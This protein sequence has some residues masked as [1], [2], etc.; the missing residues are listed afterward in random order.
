MSLILFLFYWLVMPVLVAFGAVWLWKKPRTRIGKAIVAAGVAASAGWL[1][2]LA[3][4]EKML[5]DMRVNRLCAKDGG[6]RVY[7]SVPLTPDL[8]DEAGRISIPDQARAKPS[9]PYFYM[10]RR[11]V[12]V[13][14]RAKVT[15]RQVQVVRKVDGKILGEK[16][17]YS[18][19]GGELPGPWH[20]S[21][22]TCP[23]PDVSRRFESEIFVGG[24]NDE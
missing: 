6:I 15:R 22:F 13:D 10:A 21:G 8:L 9:D 23:S 3:A 18:R 4:G 2:W 17:S 19:T 11:D 14:G 16:I 24:M 7:E 12:V 1:L 5:A 20:S